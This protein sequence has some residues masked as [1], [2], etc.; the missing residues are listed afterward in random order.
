MVRPTSDLSA[1]QDLDIE[2][3][4][5]DISEIDSVK[6]AMNGCGT[7][8]Y[9]VVD[10]RAWLVDSAPLYRTNFDGLTNVLDAAIAENITRFVF[11][12][13]MVTLPRHSGSPAVEEHAFDWW[14]EAPDYVKTRVLAEKAVTDAVAERDFPLSC[15]VS[16]TP[17]ALRIMAQHLTEM[18][19]GRQQKVKA[20]HSTAACRR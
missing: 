16:P 10:T 7:I 6:A 5:G 17:M 3:C 11:T 4:H 19:S 20:R 18:R 2:I 15:S 8:F 13:S 14:D 1:L 9:N 12:S